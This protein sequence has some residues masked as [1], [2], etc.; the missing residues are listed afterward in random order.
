MKIV[1]INAN[2]HGNL[3]RY[4][5]FIRLPGAIAFWRKTVFQSGSDQENA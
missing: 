5:R 1:S 2:S 4:G 3:I